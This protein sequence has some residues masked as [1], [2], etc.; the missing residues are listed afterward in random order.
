MA[1][2]TVWLPAAALGMLALSVPAFWPFYLARPLDADRYT[3]AHA[4]LGTLWLL[5]LMVQPWLIRGRRLGLHRRLGWGGAVLGVAFVISSVLLTHH[6]VSRLDAET[7]ARDGAGFYLPLAMAALFASALLLAVR[8]RRVMPLHARYMAC[9]LLAL[10]DPIVARLLVAS[11]LPLPVAELYQA[12]A[13][14]I[15]LTVLVA[16]ARTLP[17]RSPGRR[18]FVGFALVVTAGLVFHFAASHVVPWVWWMHWF[19]SLPLT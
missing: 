7:F 3:H 8:R 18:E 1:T 15:I 9:T 4:L 17:E 16:M 19:R 10:V 12:P 2:W 11:G 5:S 13:F 6:R 14:L